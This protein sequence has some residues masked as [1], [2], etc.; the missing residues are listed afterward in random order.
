MQPF[1]TTIQ[2]PDKSPLELQIRTQVLHS[3]ATWLHKES[4]KN[5]SP[6]RIY[7]YPR[8]TYL[9]SSPNE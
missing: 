3:P 9:R 2:A 8:L 5:V 6:S 4:E 1:H 7:M